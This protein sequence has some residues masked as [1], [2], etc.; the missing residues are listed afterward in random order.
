MFVSDALLSRISCRKF[1]PDPVSEETVRDIIDKARW[2]PSG[3][4]LQPWHLYAM[5]GEPLANLLQ[6]IAK[7]MEATPRG[8]PTEYRVY[9]EDLKDPYEARRFKCGEDLYASI[10]VSREDKPGRIKQF[11]HNFE[12]FG[13]PVGLF[14]YIDRSMGPPQ[15]SDVGMFLQSLM[16]VARDYGL[17]TCAQEAWAQWHQTIADHLHP[18]EQW[19]LFCGICLGYMDQNAPIN[20]LRTERESVDEV[21]NWVGF[22]DD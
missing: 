19:M 21:T 1:L 14:V 15:W 13:A 3:G 6:D 12:L 9:P 2:A 16:L 8:E 10:G 5:T 11:R 22:G 20:Q 17:H 4:N 18:S 7:K